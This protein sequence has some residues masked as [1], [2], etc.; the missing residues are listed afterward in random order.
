MNKRNP[1]PVGANTL[2]RVG[3]LLP[4]CLLILILKMV[5]L[6]ARMVS[7]ALNKVK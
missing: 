3:L 5:S 2:A 7:M 1:K 6:R 4:F